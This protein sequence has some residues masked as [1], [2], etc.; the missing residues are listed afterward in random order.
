VR[1]N[2]LPTAI[3]ASR[4]FSLQSLM[5]VAPPP[6]LLHS[7]GDGITVY[8]ER[9]ANARGKKYLNFF[10]FQSPLFRGSLVS[11]E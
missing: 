8:Q 2:L 1:T 10:D 7:I 11:K 9:W 6:F 3:T 4:H 5:R